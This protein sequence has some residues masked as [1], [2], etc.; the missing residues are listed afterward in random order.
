MRVVRRSGGGRGLCGGPGKEWVVLVELCR[1]GTRL[2][3]ERWLKLLFLEELTSGALRT[4]VWLVHF[5]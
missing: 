3:G 5:T 4:T 1:T 2:L